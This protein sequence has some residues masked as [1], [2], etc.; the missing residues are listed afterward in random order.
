MM[1]EFA[2]RSLCFAVHCS[3]F[4]VSRSWATWQ[5]IRKIRLLPQTILFSCV[6]SMKAVHA[7]EYLSPCVGGVGGVGTSLIVVYILCFALF[8]VLHGRWIHWARLRTRAFTSCS[9]GVLR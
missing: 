4:S 5:W 8:D 7:I 6:S 1:L 2:V 3:R 9:P